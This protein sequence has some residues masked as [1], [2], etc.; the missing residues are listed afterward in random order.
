[1]VHLFGNIEMFEIQSILKNV[2]FPLYL[3]E[4]ILKLYRSNSYVIRIYRSK[5]YLNLVVLQLAV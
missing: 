3:F 5:S 1:M 4:I 2:I